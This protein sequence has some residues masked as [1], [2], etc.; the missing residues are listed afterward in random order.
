VDIDPEIKKENDNQRRYLENS[1]N[2]LKK[3][4][5]KETKVHKEDNLNIMRENMRL[6]QE[7]THLRKNVTSLDL[8]LK[9]NTSKSKDDSNA[10]EGQDQAKE[11]AQN[12]YRES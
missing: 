12:Q 4:L 1:V 10:D 8:K 11:I 5:E 2:S 7:I 6:I 9:N 3:R